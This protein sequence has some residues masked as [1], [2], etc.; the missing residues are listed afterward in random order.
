MKYYA[1]KSKL[2]LNV[3]FTNVLLILRLLDLF[4]SARLWILWPDFCR[5][6]RVISRMYKPSKI[7]DATCHWRPSYHWSALSALPDGTTL[8]FN[9][10]HSTPSP[11]FFIKCVIVCGSLNVVKSLRHQWPCV[12]SLLHWCEQPSWFVVF[13][14]GTCPRAAYNRGHLLDTCRHRNSRASEIKTTTPLAGSVYA[15]LLEREELKKNINWLIQR[16]KNELDYPVSR[17]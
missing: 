16:N 3:L 5:T 8:Q 14:H 7:F 12:I 17:D 13:P 15:R 2:I 6:L 9:V 4:E 1:F 10:A 11:H